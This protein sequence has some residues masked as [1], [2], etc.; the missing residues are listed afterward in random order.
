M[1]FN[2]SEIRSTVGDSALLTSAELR[3]LIKYT[4][5]IK[6]QR[7]ELYYSSEGSA[8]YHASRFIHNNQ[9]NTWLSFDVTEP[10]KQWL[11]QAGE[12]AATRL[13]RFYV[14]ACFFPKP[15]DVCLPEDEQSFQLR[16][17]CEC[18]EP[19]STFQLS[20]SGT[21]NN[22]GDTGTMRTMSEQPPYIL[23]MSI[24]QNMSSHLTSRKKR[25][26]AAQETCTA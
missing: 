7:V 12:V 20:I 10:L 4:R 18:G 11:G 3:M 5:I 19:S 14:S 1:F 24:P 23:T 26:T 22:R 25:S 6:E 9:K 13:I 17:F 15:T 2:V 21:D 8:R 16:V